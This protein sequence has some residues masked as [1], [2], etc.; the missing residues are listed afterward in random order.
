MP[1]ERNLQKE[2]KNLLTIK[3]LSVEYR[4]LEG[5]F[6]AIN[7]VSLS[8]KEGISMGLVG[9][10]GA[11]KTSL[12]LSIL[13]LLPEQGFIT[14]GEIIFDNRDLIKISQKEIR[15]IRGNE[16]SM[17]FQDP[18]SSLNPVFSVA[19]Q[20]SETIKVH[21]KIKWREA[22]QRTNELLYSVG[23]S[24]DRANQFP[25]EFSGGM[26]QRVM[27]AIALACEPRLLIADEPT[28]AL[29]VTIQAQIIELIKEV[30][31]EF[32]TSLIFIS[33]DLGII[34]EIC[35]FVEVMY[36]GRIVESGTTEELYLNPMHPYTK[37]LFNC[38]PDIDEPDKKLIPIDG[39]SPSPKI[40]FK[41]CPFY[42][43]CKDASKYC[44][45]NMPKMIKVSEF[46]QVA[47]LKC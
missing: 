4:T 5:V 34:P 45:N 2:V 27:I 42:P 31:K 38:V 22:Y 9:E 14:K 32:K 19:D 24:I 8:L 40:I 1:T 39:F 12:A 18:M 29:D 21:K 25:H 30:N 47:C 46:H 10:T 41:G 16:I 15:S 3:D 17:V 33:H 43:R 13:R 6:Y 20:I 23:I 28:T 37:G 11:G 26:V 7:G 35:E 44:E 36:A